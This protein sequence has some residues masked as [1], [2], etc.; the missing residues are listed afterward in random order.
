MSASSDFLVK[1][2][3]ERWRPFVGA[4]SLCGLCATGGYMFHSR[5]VAV[6]EREQLERC[7]MELK[8]RHDV[9]VVFRRLDIDAQD[10]LEAQRSRWSERSCLALP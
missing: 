6:R 8:P 5:F 9:Q 7:E 1:V 3:P 2:L 10:F 4:L